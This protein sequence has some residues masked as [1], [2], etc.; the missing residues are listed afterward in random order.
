MKWMKIL[1]DRTVNIASMYTGT[2]I[3][4]MAMNQIVFFGF[5]LNP[6]CLVAA[7]PHVLLITVFI[8]S[9]VNKRN[10]WGNTWA[11]KGVSSIMDRPSMTNEEEHKLQVLYANLP[12]VPDFNLEIDTSGSEVEEYCLPTGY[13]AKLMRITKYQHIT[14]NNENVFFN[15]KNKKNNFSLEMVGIEKIDLYDGLLWSRLKFTLQTKCQVVVPGLP[16]KKASIFYKLLSVDFSE[17]Y[18]SN[19]FLIARNGLKIYPMEDQYFKKNVLDK[20]NAN[21]E[22]FNS[23]F[24]YLN[25]SPKI[26]HHKRVFDFISSLTEQGE[27]IRGKH[28]YLFM[29]NEKVI[30]NSFFAS[31]EM[32]PLTEKQ[33]EAS[34]INEMANLVVAGAGSGKTSVM[35]ARAGYLIKK[36]LAT[37]DEILLVAFNKLAATELKDRLKEKL[38]LENIQAKTFHSLGLEVIAKATKTKPSLAPWEQSSLVLE[39]LIWEIVEEEIKNT[40]LYSKLLKFFVYHI[41]TYKSSF[42]FEDEIEYNKYVYDSNLLPIRESIEKTSKKLITFKNAQRVKSFE[43]LEIANFLYLNNV[44]YEYERSYEFNTATELHRQYEPD[45]YLPQYK[46]YLEHFGI[47]KKGNTAP[48]VDREQYNDSIKWKRTLHEEKGTKL[49]ETYSWMRQEGHLLDSLEWLLLK[50]N[51]AL[52]PM[53]YKEA[54]DKLNAAGRVSKFANIMATFINH[55]R[56]NRHTFEKIRALAKN[57]ERSNLFIAIAEPVMIRYEAIK[58]EKDVIDF[59]DM[60]EIAINHIKSGQYKSHYKFIL[61]DEFQDISIARAEFITALFEQKEG[62]VLTAVGDDWQ[63]INR[64]SGSDISIFRDFS[65]FFGYSEVVKL[66]YS[67]RYSDKI[68]SVSQ[69]FVES[70]PSQIKKEIKTLTKAVEKPILHFWDVHDIH[71]TVDNILARIVKKQSNAS[72]LIL[73]RYKFK[74][75]ENFSTLQNKHHSLSIRQMTIHGSKGLESD[76]VILLGLEGGKFGFPSNIEDDPVIDLVLSD[77]EEFEHGE[78]RRLFYVVLT[79]A[80]KTVFIL[81]D[82]S[83]SSVFSK[84]ILSS[85][86]DGEVLHVTPNNMKPEHCPGCETGLLLIKQGNYGLFYGCANFKSGCTY[87]KPVSSCPDCFTGIIHKD[88]STDEYKCNQC[89]FIPKICILCGGFMSLKKGRNGDFYGCSNYSKNGCRHTENC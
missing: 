32:N 34:I 33:I 3:V 25:T 9:W 82:Q 62:C 58:K 35:V 72:V 77:G 29:R 11:K 80:K 85:E 67:F 70:N 5:C 68:S 78:E 37:E 22:F 48:Y 39:K 26:E 65:N 49:I 6:A 43:E 36:G 89:S 16:R 18:Y 55:M 53:P 87:T 14:I 69:R 40:E 61:A 50:N 23:N 13:F 79:R 27:L 19:F 76:F 15:L 38:H 46:I 63:S 83:N 17:H 41:S 54:L 81:G 2:F 28:N 66:D 8:G 10:N 51:V 7:M 4:V 52:N 31:V 12:D 84:E 1:F 64:F 42:D 21:T 75:L 59:N 56:S 74:L 88:F 44:E 86:Y 71:K 57:D 24:K 20:I 73:A 30:Y 45:F 47:D 60:I